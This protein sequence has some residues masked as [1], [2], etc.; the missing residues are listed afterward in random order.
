MKV[1]QELDSEYEK[2]KDDYKELYAEC[3]TLNAEKKMLEKWLEEAEPK[4]SGPPSDKDFSDEVVEVTEPSKEIKV[5]YTRSRGSKALGEKVEIPIHIPD[6]AADIVFH[7]KAEGKRKLDEVPEMVEEDEPV[8]KAR[9]EET[10][11]LEPVQA[12]TA[13][14]TEVIDV[15][16]EVDFTDSEPEANI[17]EDIPGEDFTNCTYKQI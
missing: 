3:N 7:D 6:D 5:Y 8:K 16:D 11:Q 12:E 1:L 15:L 17:G 9:I 2:L 13:P 10:V 4:R 14:T